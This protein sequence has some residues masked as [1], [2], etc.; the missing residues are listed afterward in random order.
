MCS[1]TWRRIGRT[2]HAL[3]EEQMPAISKVCDAI[4]LLI[5]IYVPII[6]LLVTD[7]T[8]H[9][10]INLRGMHLMRSLRVAKA[11]FLSFGLIVSA[12]EEK[13]ITSRQ[14]TGYEHKEV[15]S[16]NK[17]RPPSLLAVTR[18]GPN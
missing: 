1:E 11:M 5:S 18:I 7:L 12:Q 16:R 3:H 4:D 8:Q 14:N 6:K 17:E 15:E 10:S 13:I 2:S 9:F